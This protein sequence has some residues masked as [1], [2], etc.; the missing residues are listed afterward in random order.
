VSGEDFVDAK[1]Q[2]S[3]ILCLVHDRVFQLS[4]CGSTLEVADPDAGFTTINY[5]Q[6]LPFVEIQA[7]SRQHA[8]LIGPCSRNYPVV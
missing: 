4:A 1:V 8:L 3:V 2:A 7:S 6:D 5:E